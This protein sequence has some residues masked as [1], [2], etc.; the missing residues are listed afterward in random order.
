MGLGVA[1]DGVGVGLAVGVGVGTPGLCVGVALDVGDG[2]G[3]EGIVVLVPEQPAPA[4]APSATR[5]NA[6]R[7]TFIV[8]TP[9]QRAPR[10]PNATMRAR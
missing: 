9:A 2:D 6:T 10:L 8:E 1:G 4:R 7:E 5:R 3:R